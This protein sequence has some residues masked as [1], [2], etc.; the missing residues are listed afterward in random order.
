M[1]NHRLIWYLES[2]NLYSES[3]CGFR[4]NRSTVDHLVRLETFIRD[5]FI[6]KEHAVGIF[7]DL[8]KSNDTTWKHGILKD[9][10]KLG[11]KGHLP[12]FISNFLSERTFRVRVGSTFSDEF[13]QEE[14]VPQGSILT[15][16]LFN[17]KINDIVKEV[18]TGVEN[19]LYV[20]DFGICFRS[21]HMRTIE[22]QLQQTLT[23]VENWATENGI[24]FHNLRRNVFIF[25]NCVVCITIQNYIFINRE[26]PWCK[27][28][29][30]LV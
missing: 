24:N 11:L 16:T 28:Q 15:T 5:V 19:S 20:D 7:F 14:G 29:N 8:E 6:R 10:S 26:F 25:V 17:I 13:N 9:L 30:F 2:N 3:Q 22:R 21:K 27:K 18:N 1:I 23:K 12:I 4:Q